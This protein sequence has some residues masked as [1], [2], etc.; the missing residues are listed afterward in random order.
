M[1]SRMSLTPP[2]RLF[3][4][5]SLTFRIIPHVEPPKN[6]SGGFGTRL[7][8]FPLPGWNNISVFVPRQLGGVH[9]PD[10]R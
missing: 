3:G 6:R 5:F 2:L 4:M 8:I 9:H 7:P 1:P 10:N